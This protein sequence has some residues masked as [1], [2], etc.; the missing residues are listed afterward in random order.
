MFWFLFGF[1]LGGYFMASC[2]KDPVYDTVCCEELK[3]KH[4]FLVEY[5][6]RILRSKHLK[7]SE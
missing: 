2:E 1:L 7:K 4:E 5:Y 3:Q 6:N